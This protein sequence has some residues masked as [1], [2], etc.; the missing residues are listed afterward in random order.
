M[1]M[2]SE[3]TNNS[4]LG[5]ENGIQRSRHLFDYFQIQRRERFEIQEKLGKEGASGRATNIIL[6]I[7][8]E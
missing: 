2:S 7:L 6:D 4:C 1:E 5:W 8:K 3:H